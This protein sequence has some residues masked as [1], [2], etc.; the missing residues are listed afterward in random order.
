MR[1]RATRAIR[2]VEGELPPTLAQFSREM[3]RGLGDVEK[4]LE[5]AAAPLR[6]E[7]V[8]VLRE[9]SHALGRYETEGERR[10]RQLTGQAR[11]EAV[12]VLRRLE[13]SL[14]GMGR[15]RAP[16]RRKSVR[17]RARPAAPSQAPVA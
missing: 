6:R 2:R 8:R 7:L 5:K 1:V 13:K 17:R 4:R 12:A 14:Q 10:W 3:R 11:R 16:A 9:A 15:S